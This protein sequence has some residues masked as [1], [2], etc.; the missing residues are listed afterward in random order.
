[1]L[2]EGKVVSRTVAVAI[3]TLCVGVLIG[4]G[5]VVW[6]E[7]S[8][9]SNYTSLV[10]SKDETMSD[11]WSRVTDL[12]VQ[13]SSMNQQIANLSNQVAVRDAQIADESVQTSVLQNR[14][15]DLEAPQII[16]VDMKAEDHKSP[17]WTEPYLYVSGHVF[18][19]GTAWAYHVRLHVV[20][21]Q[22]GGVVAIDAY[23]ERG[24]LWG[25][26][27]I[28]VDANIPYLGE[29]LSDW[30]ITPEWTDTL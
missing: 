19:A 23:I 21:H 9:I 18:N 6:N 15:A 11:L 25:R 26:W 2:S 5:I 16:S 1:M 30:T 27:W 10:N 13:I 7:N 3:G 17:E 14:V 20:A 4:L 29:A 22:T 8:I 12:Q 28:E 24:N